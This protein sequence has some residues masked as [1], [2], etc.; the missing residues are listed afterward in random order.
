MRIEPTALTALSSL[1]LFLPAT[2]RAE[3][4]LWIVPQN[5]ETLQILT[6]DLL[7][8]DAGGTEITSYS[9]TSRGTLNWHGTYFIYQPGN[10]FWQAGMDSFRYEFT[11]TPSGSAIVFLVA[12][13]L[14]NADIT[15]GLSLVSNP[16]SLSLQQGTLGPSTI[17]PFPES[18]TLAS[19]N[20]LKVIVTAQKDNGSGDDTGGVGG[21]IDPVGLA[22]V[23]GDELTIA[24]FAVGNSEDDV[25]LLLK[26]DGDGFQLKARGKLC[27]GAMIDTPWTETPGEIQTVTVQWWS[28]SLESARD[29]GLAIQR[30]GR[31]IAS[32]SGVDCLAASQPLNFAARY[33]LIDP[34]AGTLGNVLLENLRAWHSLF[35][36]PNLEPI[37]ADGVE[38][39]DLAAWSNSLGPVTVTPAAA[40]LGSSGLSIPA[41]GPAYV[42]DA[43]PMDEDRVRARF[44]IDPGQLTMAEGQRLTVLASYEADGV[45]RPFSLFLRRQSGAFELCAEAKENGGPP[46]TTSCFA[47]DPG[48]HLVKVQWW[49]SVG[50]LENNGGLALFID[51]LLRTTETGLT[52]DDLAIAEFRLGALDP[53][54]GTSGTVYLDDF[55]TWR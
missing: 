35:G 8:N 21:D 40:I 38:S 37:F 3:N 43:T 52:N 50:S 31:V 42:I 6:S 34:S 44:N 13:V 39:G 47:L 22:L 5:E 25:S 30:D 36:R 2:V 46:V 17:D 12:D 53:E 24:D 11:G 15:L 27:N 23:P 19:V 7:E 14:G 10:L 33:G 1:L 51:S 28:E 29:G 49:S 54:A 4:D 20:G 16:S 9:P 48:A 32:A 41:S 55:E 26:N 18:I 45:S